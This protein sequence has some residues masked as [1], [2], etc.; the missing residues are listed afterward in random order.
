MRVL[1]ATRSFRLW[2]VA[3]LFAR[4]PL[5]MQLLA[6]VLAGEAATGSLAIGAQLGAV[7]SFV[8]AA[9]ARVQEAERDEDD[10]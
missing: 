4:L 5:T 6:L 7:R 2:A 1:L 10:G 3:N 8:D 9:W